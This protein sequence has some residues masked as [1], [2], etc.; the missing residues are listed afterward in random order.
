MPHGS[1]IW[2]EE[3]TVVFPHTKNVFA[4]FYRKINN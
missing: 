2:V 4:S 1:E 3:V